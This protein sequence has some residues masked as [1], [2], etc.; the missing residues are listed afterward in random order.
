MNLLL[1]I[2][3][4]A[5]HFWPGFRKA[6][7]RMDHQAA[8]VAIFFAWCSIFVGLNYFYWSQW[9]PNWLANSLLAVLVL[10]AAAHGIRP[11]LMGV[12]PSVSQLN[13]DLASQ[14][15]LRFRLA[16]E[17]Y[18]QGDYFQAE[19]YLL[20]NLEVNEVDI[21]SALLLSSVYRRAGK[22]VDAMETLNQLLLREDARRWE[23][24]ILI[25]KERVI[26]TKRQSLS[27]PPP[28]A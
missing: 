14:V 21:E 3:R 15:D 20:K 12:H 27:S 2:P 10:T 26:R 23:G 24:E 22:F 11:L 25:E 1:G 28:K 16:Q 5:S 13:A 17:S 4:I 8:I 19:Q 7:D 9:Y 18:L 6:W